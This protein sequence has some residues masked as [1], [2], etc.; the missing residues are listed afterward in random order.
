VFPVTPFNSVPSL[1]GE[2]FYPDRTDEDTEA[3]KGR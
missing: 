3:Q 2:D 1:Q